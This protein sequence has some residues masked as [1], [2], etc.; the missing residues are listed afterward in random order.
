MRVGSSADEATQ[1]LHIVRGILDER[2]VGIEALTTGVAERSSHDR[3]A[4]ELVERGLPVGGGRRQKTG[5]PVD[6]CLVVRPHR[7]CDTG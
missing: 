7:R 6:D 2:I 5:L 1:Q 3:I 4:D